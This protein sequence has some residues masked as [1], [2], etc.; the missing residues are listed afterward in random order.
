[1]ISVARVTTTK[2]ERNYST[3]QLAPRFN[4]KRTASRVAC[5]LASPCCCSPAQPASW[6]AL[7]M[8]CLTPRHTP[9]YVLATACS[10]GSRPAHRLA[11]ALCPAPAR[12]APHP[13]L[14]VGR[15]DL[16]SSH[17]TSSL[18]PVVGEP[19]SLSKGPPQA[20]PASRGSGFKTSLHISEDDRSCFARSKGNKGLQVKVWI[21]GRNESFWSCESRDHKMEVTQWRATKVI[22]SAPARVAVPL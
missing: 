11:H 22:A 3:Y 15:H 8:T 12:A 21:G 6:S 19:L 5:D 20:T 14:C 7:F 13:H 10:P 2:S 18:L 1:M 17:I 4:D 16:P 9:T